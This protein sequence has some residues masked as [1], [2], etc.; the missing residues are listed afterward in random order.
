MV[1]GMDI[2]EYLVS[3]PGLFHLAEHIVSFLDDTSVAHLRLVSKYSNELLENIWRN[4]ARK[5]AFRLCEQ[6]LTIYADEAFNEIE[7]SI[8]KSW[9]EWKNAL[10]EIENLPHWSE[11]KT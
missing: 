7:I 4:R 6:K 8:F 9:P 11:R 3:N 1:S 2:L 10:R 5:E